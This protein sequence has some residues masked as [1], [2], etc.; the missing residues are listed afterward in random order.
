MRASRNVV[1]TLKAPTLREQAEPL[2]ERVREK[3]WTA[4]RLLELHLTALTGQVPD[5]ATVRRRIRRTGVVRPDTAS[6]K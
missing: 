2:A 4:T 3:S 5:R 1:R 6:L